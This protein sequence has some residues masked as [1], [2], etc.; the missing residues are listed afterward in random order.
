MSLPEPCSWGPAFC[1]LSPDEKYGAFKEW[2][3]NNNSN[4]E[5]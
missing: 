1:G 5:R 3:E 2:S 4:M